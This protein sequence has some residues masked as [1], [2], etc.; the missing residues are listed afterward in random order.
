L[1][2]EHII[3]YS[4]HDKI[5]RLEVLLTAAGY[6]A[7]AAGEWQQWHSKTAAFDA[8]KKVAGTFTLSLS[9]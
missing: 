8:Q 9:L 1:W 3:S 4:V 6:A 2:R 5:F 7:T